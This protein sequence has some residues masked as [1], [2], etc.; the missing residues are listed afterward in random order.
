M[1]STSVS[2]KSN[3]FLS[4]LCNSTNRRSTRAVHVT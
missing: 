4:A 1:P 2:Y 3:S